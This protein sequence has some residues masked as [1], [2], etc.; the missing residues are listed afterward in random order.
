[1]IVVNLVVGN[2][3]RYKA[4]TAK[5]GDAVTPEALK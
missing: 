2:A 4:L 3:L 5:V 1:M